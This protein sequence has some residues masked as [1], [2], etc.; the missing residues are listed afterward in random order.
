VKK[1]SKNIKST[2]ITELAKIH[3]LIRGKIPKDIDYKKEIEKA[4]IEKFI[5][6]V[7]R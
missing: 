4:K 5:D 3:E 2:A 1:S 7:S 6:L